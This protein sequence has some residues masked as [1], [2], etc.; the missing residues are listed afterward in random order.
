MKTEGKG[1][2]WP[3]FEDANLT[4]WTFQDTSASHLYHSI[5]F[6]PKVINGEGV[7]S[8]LSL[9]RKLMLFFPTQDL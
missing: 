2:Q 1:E 7:E 3:H 9:V 6:I 8:C 5:E 4:L